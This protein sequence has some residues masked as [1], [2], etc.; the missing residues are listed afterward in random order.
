[1]KNIV[2]KLTA[3]FLLAATF[4]PLVMGQKKNAYRLLLMDANEE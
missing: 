3:S 1:M 4:T 2:F